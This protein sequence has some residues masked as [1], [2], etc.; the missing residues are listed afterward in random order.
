MRISIGQLRRIIKEAATVEPVGNEIPKCPKHED[1]M[2]VGK[3]LG[4]YCPECEDVFQ[5]YTDTPATIS[6]EEPDLEN[7]VKNAIDFYK[8]NPITW[9]SARPDFEAMAV[10]DQ[11]GGTRNKYYKG[12][13]NYHFRRVLNL[14]GQ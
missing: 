8:K 7:H 13:T 12:W 9:N 10:G 2:V 11:L 3:R 6:P 4:W 5:L 14:M 1:A